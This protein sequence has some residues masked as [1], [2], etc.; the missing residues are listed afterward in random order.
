MG[1]YL[2]RLS[3]AKR[4]RRIRKALRREICGNT[5]HKQ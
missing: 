5:K 3:H 4:T 1:S 2:W